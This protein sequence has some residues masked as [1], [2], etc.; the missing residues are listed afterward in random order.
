MHADTLI[1]RPTNGASGMRRLFG[2]E[3]VPHSSALLRREVRSTSL[4]RGKGVVFRRDI[5]V[6]RVRALSR[7]C[8]STMKI[9]WVAKSHRW[10]TAIRAIGP[11]STLGGIYDCV[12]WRF[13]RRWVQCTDPEPHA[14]VS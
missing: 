3:L 8:E 4:I 9:R 14:P 10:T 1:L 6:P 13:G 5:A 11:A 7:C 2:H 12:A